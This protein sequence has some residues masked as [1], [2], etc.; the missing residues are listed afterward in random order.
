VKGEPEIEK[1]EF[2]GNDAVPRLGDQLPIRHWSSARETKSPRRPYKDCFFNHDPFI[3]LD[4]VFDQFYLSSFV[5][6]ASLPCYQ[7]ISSN[8]PILYVL[9]LAC[10][11]HSLHM[12]HV[13]ISALPTLLFFFALTTHLSALAPGYPYAAQLP[14]GAAA[15]AL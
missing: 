1:L 11:V 3:E 15:R 14:A 4:T 7:A 2:G 5:S 8:F 9:L 13:L 10:P 6:K 12:S